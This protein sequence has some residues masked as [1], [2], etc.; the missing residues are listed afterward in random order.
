MCLLWFGICLFVLKIALIENKN[1]LEFACLSGD[2]RREQFICEE[3]RKRCGKKIIKTQKLYCDF[4]LSFAIKMS[5]SWQINVD[6]NRFLLS[7]FNRKLIRV[8]KLNGVE[9]HTSLQAHRLGWRPVRCSQSLWR[10][11]EYGFPLF[12][13][14]PMYLFVCSAAF[15]LSV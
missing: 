15:H 6:G 8:L 12:I 3:F 11:K 7:P 4:A 9:F 1:P 2:G 5:S 13:T 10:N 14:Y